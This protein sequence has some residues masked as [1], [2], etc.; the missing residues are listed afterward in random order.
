M[1]LA[2][3]RRSAAAQ[4][5]KSGK[6]GSC[7]T[8]SYFLVPFFLVATIRERSPGV[9]Q[10]RVFTGRDGTGRPTQTSVTVRGGKREA[11]REAARLESAPQRGAGGRTV[12]DALDGWLERN[13]GS[14]TPASLR[15]QT[16]RVR[17]VQ[18]D[19]IARTPLARL[20]VAEVDR[21]LTRMRRS[22]L[23]DAAIRNRL[24][25]LRAALQQAVVWGWIPSNPAALTRPPGVKRTPRDVMSP[26]DAVAVIKAAADSDPL[27]GL[28]L[29]LAAVAGARRAELAALRWTDLD[30]SVLTVDSA[31]T[32]IRGE[33]DGTEASR[34]VDTRTKTAERHT[35]TLD[36]ETVRLW[37]ELRIEYEPYGP[38]V[39]N[40]GEGPPSPDR[41]GWWWR[42]AREASGIDK[43]WRL[44]DLRHFSATM[45]IA[46]GHDVRTVA[47]RLGHSDP[48]MTLR[49][50]AHAVEAADRGIADLLGDV[51]DGSAGAAEAAG[52]G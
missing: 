30:G 14:Y 46:G 5:Y 37:N 49:V 18:K 7:P 22:G 16:S 23:G 40:I 26:A 45:A 25:V 10:V 43:R 47:H 52:K 4:I 27:A 19:A 21:W 11:L 12:S 51:L 1:S 31:I 8:L 15:D 35:V 13:E 39:F 36:T 42:C 38:Y 32:V 2:F 28:A 20:G 34:F 29:R 41:I 17:L 44:H 24:T 48:A 33:G 6:M 3:R 9:W 50:Y